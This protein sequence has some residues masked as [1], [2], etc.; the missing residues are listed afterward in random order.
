MAQTQP[1]IFFHHVLSSLGPMPHHD[2]H[3]N[4]SPQVGHKLLEGRGL[5]FIAVLYNLRR[6]SIMFLDKPGGK[7]QKLKMEEPSKDR[8]RH[9]TSED[10]AW[11]G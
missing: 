5:H 9:S 8:V 7:Y 10:S 3:V 11:R 1:N 6:P 2:L 4:S